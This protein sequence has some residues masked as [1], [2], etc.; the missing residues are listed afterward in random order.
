MRVT[1]IDNWS[2]TEPH[3]ATTWEKRR[4]RGRTARRDGE[5]RRDDHDEHDHDDD[6]GGWVGAFIQSINQSVGLSL[7]LIDRSDRLE[8]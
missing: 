4:R 6:R 2:Q 1:T 7:S 5:R 8:R 3:D